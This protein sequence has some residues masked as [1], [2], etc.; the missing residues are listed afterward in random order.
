MEFT[1]II[2]KSTGSERIMDGYRFV[3]VGESVGNLHSG[4]LDAFYDVWDGNIEQGEDGNLYLVQR[5][6]FRAEDVTP[7]IWCK[8]EREDRTLVYKQDGACWAWHRKMDEDEDGHFTRY[9]TTNAA[10]AGI[11][12]VDLKR[13]NRTQLVGTWD[14]SLAGIKD[15]RRKIRNWMNEKR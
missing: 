4:D 5:L 6:T 3:G 10:G 11:F 7:V 14:F 9:W 12:V 8:V 2:K 1:K 15:P 13:N